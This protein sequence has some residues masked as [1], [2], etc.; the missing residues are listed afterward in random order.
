MGLLTR[1]IK[2]LLA[3][4]LGG[5]LTSLVLWILDLSGVFR[6]ASI[7]LSVPETVTYWIAQRVMRDLPWALL[8]LL[9]VRLDWPQWKRGMVLGLG[10]ALVLLLYWLPMQDFGLLGLRGGWGL[11]VSALAFSLLWGAATGHFLA[12]QGEGRRNAPVEEWSE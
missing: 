5:I 7:P 9:P 1:V 11:P 6:L 8:L 4:V 3:G 10:P 2:A 12:L